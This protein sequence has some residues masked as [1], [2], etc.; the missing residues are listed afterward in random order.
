MLRVLALSAMTSMAAAELSLGSGSGSAMLPD[1]TPAPPPMVEP[2]ITSMEGDFHVE[3]GEENDCVMCGHSMNG[4]VADVAAVTDSVHQL[5]MNVNSELSTLE[6]EVSVAQQQLQD[7]GHFNLTSVQ[8]ALRQ[9]ID[10]VQST[11]DLAANCAAS[12]QLLDANGQCV[13]AQ[14]RCRAVLQTPSNSVGGY[15]YH[16]G[17]GR[18]ELMNQ[19]SENAVAKFMG[20]VARWRCRPGFVPA[21]DG[22]SVCLSSGRWSVG[23]PQCQSCAS[24]YGSGCTSCDADHCLSCASN[25]QYNAEVGGC[26][27]VCV[28]NGNG[29]QLGSLNMA[30]TGVAWS[31]NPYYHSSW[32]PARIIDNNLGTGYHSGNTE[33]V[34]DW[35]HLTVTL[36]RNNLNVPITNATTIP[37]VKEVRLYGRS[38]YQRNRNR[39]IGVDIQDYDTGVWKP[40]TRYYYS[41]SN[42]NRWARHNCNHRGKVIRMRRDRQYGNWVNIMELQAYGNR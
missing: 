34:P 30:R 22:Q 26:V 40:C 41:Q 2:K 10:T 21:G 9:G 5:A 42:S 28:N 19:G 11:L 27:Q 33:W 20:T 8:A 3:V 31:P 16:V 1:E 14:I 29:Q 15:T 23:N 17:D 6:D 4:V 13:Q 18:P 37:C 36:S 38:N 25:H 24:R 7:E 32:R 35:A 39:Y 12:G